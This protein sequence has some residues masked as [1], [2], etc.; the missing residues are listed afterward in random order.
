MLVKTTLYSGGFTFTSHP[1]VQKSEDKN[2][3]E[4][5]RNE[6]DKSMDRRA[7]LEQAPS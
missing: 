5:E 1:K 2:S 3:S 7:F 4:K 6:G